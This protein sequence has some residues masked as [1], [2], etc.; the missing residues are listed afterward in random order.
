MIQQNDAA[1]RLNSG[2]SPTLIAQNNAVGSWELLSYSCPINPIHAALLRTGKV[3]F[4]AGSGN[5]SN[6]RNDTRGSAVLDL[7]AGTFSRPLTP[8]DAAGFPLDLFCVG[9]SFRANGTL[10][11]AGG[12]LQYDPFYGSTATLVFNPVT[13][14]WTQIQSMNSGRWYPTVVTLGSGRTFTLSGLDVNGQLDVY[15]EIYSSAFATGWNAFSQR[16]T[17]RFP[18][19]SHLFLLSSGRLFYSGGYF[20]NTGVSPRLLTLP[21]S[22]TQPIS[23]QAVTGLAAQNFGE[24]AAS[25]LL[26]PA[27][28]QRV[29][30]TGGGDGFFGQAT[31]RVSIVDLTVSNPTYTAAAPLNFARMHHN[32]VI[33]P[34]RTVF[35]CNGSARGE[36]LDQS[37]LPAEIYNPA[38]NSWTVAATPNLSGRVYHSVAVLLPDGRVLVTGGNPDRGIEERR[39][40]IYSPPYMSQSRPQIQSAAQTVSY[41]GTVTIQSPQ[42]PDI[43]WVSL[44]R[45]MAT[46]HSCETEQRLVDVP[47][48][49]RTS[50]SVTTTVPINRN[51]A[52][53]GY[54]MLFITN[55]S[56]VPSV[57][58]WIQLT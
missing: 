17:S 13:E 42:A 3:L 27:Q 18:M 30:I 46:T 32:A 35:V 15:P 36:N 21:L 11:A 51:L 6:N 48:T 50:T 54:Y 47:I 52:P 31:N 9:H 38:T 12:T 33:L 45:P 58:R 22:F 44:I 10:L 25:V 20:E 53:P 8:N 14:Q 40:E 43:Q 26:P 1:T 4:I 49:S 7:S 37:D 28:D 23:E 41:G 5:D 55:S 34:D 57:A 56:G 16:T 29:M 19:Y 24:Q 2:E 39:I